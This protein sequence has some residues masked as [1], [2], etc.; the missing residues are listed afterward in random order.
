MSIKSSIVTKTGDNGTTGLLYGVR[1][2]KSHIKI[3][4]CGALDELNSTLGVVK[5]YSNNVDFK[6]F[7]RKIQDH[8]FI[9][10]GEIS[11]PSEYHEKRYKITEEMLRFVEFEIKR[12]ESAKILM[13]NWA[14]PGENK[15]AAH[16]DVAR[17][18]CRRLERWCVILSEEGL[19]KND[20]LLKYVNRLSDLLWLLAREAELEN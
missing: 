16:L 9:L 13:D 8:S 5:A 15:L 12:L 7:I 4:A 1:V 6:A 14:I 2:S 20:T 11:T 3:E 19:I 17:S 10:G 18:I